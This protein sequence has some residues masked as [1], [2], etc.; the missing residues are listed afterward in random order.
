MALLTRVL[1]C[2]YMDPLYR[3]VTI[4]GI[5]GMISFVALIFWPAGT[6]HYWQGWLFFA[7]F[8]LS[9]FVSTIYV[10]LYDKPLLER[11]L[12]AGPRHEKERSQ[13]IIVS[14]IFVAFFAL[15]VLSVL[16]HRCG[17]S[18]VPPGVTIAGDVLIVLS[19]LFI[20]WVIKVN[21]YAASNIRVEKSQTVIDT[22]P[23]AYVRHPM[24]AGAIWMLVGIPLALG[25]W[26][27]TLLSVS[28]FPLFIWRLLDEEKI[29][30]RDLRG[31]TEYSQR[32]RY[33]LIPYL[34]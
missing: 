33:R 25:A 34:W 21:S 8:G 11:R 10:A 16:D 14:L 17:W 15:I 23:Y 26:W 1:E 12:A 6:F 4:Q 7:V 22:G 2:C 5:L 9:T 28:C 27:W 19:F 20:F 18:P 13:K 29:L 31:Y 24:Y 32:V 30:R 3:R